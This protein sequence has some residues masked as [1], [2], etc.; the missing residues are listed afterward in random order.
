MNLCN[1][2]FIIMTKKRL[3]CSIMSMLL[4]CMLCAQSAFG[5]KLAVTGNVTD[6]NGYPV[7]G[8]SVLVEGTTNGTIT[9]MDGNFKLSDVPAKGNLQVSFIGY[10]PQTIKVN[11]QTKFDIKLLEDTQTLDEVVMVGYSVMRK[12]DLTGSVASV[13]ASDAIKSTPVAN[14]SDALQGRLAGVSIAGGG[15]PSKSAAI[16]IRGVNSVTADV[17]PLLVVDG[18]I[19]GSLKNI[20]PN[21]IQSIEVLKDASATAVYGSRA[22]NGVILVTTKN[23]KEDKVVINFNAFANLKTVLDK[24]D[25]LSAGEFAELANDYAK[26]F[27]ANKPR[28]PYYTEEQIADFKQGKGGY[29]YVDHIFNEPAVAQ[30]YDLSIA[31]KSGKT[32]Y[33]ASFRYENTDG[34]I[35]E[36]SEE[37]TSELQ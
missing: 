14:V 26:E 12:S 31:G 13:K 7:I 9:D 36:R 6:N 23:A 35:K 33:L 32:S 10:K 8:A 4:F 5:Q 24:P 20:N 11:G 34:V 3:F 30:N 28:A 16:R 15:D 1:I 27:F 29:N 21:D 17:E 25:V 19:G 22:A 2:K 18:F 37:H